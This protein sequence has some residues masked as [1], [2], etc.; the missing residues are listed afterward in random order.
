MPASAEEG[1]KRTQKTTWSL[2]NLSHPNRIELAH[3]LE[4][5]ARES[6]T[7]ATFHG[8]LVNCP[9]SKPP[10]VSGLPAPPTAPFVARLCRHM[11]ANGHARPALTWA[12]VRR[13]HG[14]QSHGRQAP[15]QRWISQSPRPKHVSHVHAFPRNAAAEL[16]QMSVWPLL[17]CWRWWDTLS[18]KTAVFEGVLMLTFCLYI[19]LSNQSVNQQVKHYQQLKLGSLPLPSPPPPS[20]HPPRLQERENEREGGGGGGRKKERK[21]GGLRRWL[22]LTWE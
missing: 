10:I 15:E 13:H 17:F 3:D 21:K 7:V 19:L 14:G 6:E 2:L 18:V 5:T 22:S 1:K 11:A 8:R 20:P 12:R 4:R 9:T 16:S